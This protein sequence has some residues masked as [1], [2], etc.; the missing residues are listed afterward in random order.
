M[1]HYYSSMLLKIFGSV[2]KILIVTEKE[3]QFE[4][5]ILINFRVS[6]AIYN[7][8]D[9]Y[10]VNSAIIKEISPVNLELTNT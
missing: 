3:N 9:L 10:V 4:I 7:G 6:L 1:L 2:K 5:L 8:M